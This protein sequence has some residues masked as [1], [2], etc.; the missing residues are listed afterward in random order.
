M[1][2]EN[3]KVNVI[4]KCAEYLLIP[5]SWQLCVVIVSWCSE[6]VLMFLFMNKY[7]CV[8]M[9][10]CIYV[11]VGI[12]IC[13]SIYFRRPCHTFFLSLFFFSFFLVFWDRHSY[14]HLELQHCYQV[15]SLSVFQD[16]RA[17]IVHRYTVSACENE[18]ES[19]HRVRCGILVWYLMKYYSTMG[20]IHGGH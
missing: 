15:E 6:W 11:Y 17:H 14:F 16:N 13:I 18:M 12:Y 7:V 9:Y 19:H 1:T 5:W 8:C 3:Y 2:W 10:V 4:Q 20:I